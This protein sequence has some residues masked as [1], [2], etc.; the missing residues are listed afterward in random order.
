MLFLVV[1]LLLINTLWKAQNKHSLERI[2][3]FVSMTTR[4]ASVNTVT[5]NCLLCQQISLL[6]ILLYSGQEQG[7]KRSCLGK[8]YLLSGITG[9]LDS[10]R[11][12]LFPRV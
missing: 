12:E 3:G 6:R 4:K 8:D 10:Y 11:A 1:L 9:L 2:L 7:F 5:A